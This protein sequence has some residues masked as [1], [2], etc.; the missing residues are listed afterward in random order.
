MSH[1]FAREKTTNPNSPPW[2]RS[3]PIR[4]LSWIVNPTR[5]PI[6]V[7]IS[8]LMV[9]KPAKSESTFGHSR[10]RSCK[11][12]AAQCLD[13]HYILTFYYLNLKHI[14]KKVQERE[15]KSL[16]SLLSQ[17]HFF[18]LIIWINNNNETEWVIRLKRE[19]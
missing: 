17:N 4:T 1:L 14:F 5:G 19:S 3:N 7:M 13:P 11:E 16:L 8:V 2:D 10:K 18:P 15:T 9:I 6:A 12:R